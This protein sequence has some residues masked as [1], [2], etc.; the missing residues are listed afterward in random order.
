MANTIHRKG[1]RL[2]IQTMSDPSLPANFLSVVHACRQRGY[3]DIVLD[4]SAVKGVFPNTAAP[5]A[6]L[7]QHYTEDGLDITFD[8]V[9]D[10]VAASSVLSPRTA[11]GAIDTPLNTVWQFNDSDAIGKLTN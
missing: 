7:I 9:S 4:F 2:I 3:E 8:N 6:G 11:E 1:N 10:Y 5:L